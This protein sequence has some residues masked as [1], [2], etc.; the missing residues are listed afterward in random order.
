MG[1]GG[2]GKMRPPSS[3]R[4][5]SRYLCVSRRFRGDA[6]KGDAFRGDASPLL[7]LKDAA[8]DHPPSRRRDAKHTYQKISRIRSMLATRHRAVAPNTA[9]AEAMSEADETF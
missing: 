4:Y 9:G 8:S 5:L 1:G 7:A 6:F 3:I 2:Y